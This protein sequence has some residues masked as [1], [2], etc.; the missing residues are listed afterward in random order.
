MK[1]ESIFSKRLKEL[2]K[3]HN[4][5][6]ADLAQKLGVVRTAITNYETN[7]TMPDPAALNE[8]ANL[9]NVSIDYLLGNTNT[10]TDNLTVKE[11]KDIAKKLDELKEIL[12]SQS[13]LLFS[14]SEMD[15]ETKEFLLASL[16]R[17]I[18]QS[19]VLAKEKFTPNKY[20]K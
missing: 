12:E 1:N 8:L 18:R 19:K 14:G 20:K 17:T 11:E 10:P 13:G 16:E 7:R 9:F 5:T 6:Q 15:D 3:E 4:L 2:R